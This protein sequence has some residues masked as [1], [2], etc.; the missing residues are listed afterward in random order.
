MKRNW[1]IIRDVL[2]AV[3]ALPSNAHIRHDQVEGHDPAEVFETMALLE[4]SGFVTG[5]VK[6]SMTGAPGGFAL[7]GGLTWD[8]HD[9]VSTLRSKTWWEKIKQLAGEK[10]LELTVDVVK[11]LAGVALKS[12]LE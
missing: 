6:P 5:T 7:I 9:L 2:V 12:V 4:K 10:G 3:E 11:G 8:G 1:D